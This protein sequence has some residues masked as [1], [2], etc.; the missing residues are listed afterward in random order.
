MSY[1]WDLKMVLFTHHIF[2]FFW[3]FYTKMN[4][5]DSYC[6]YVELLLAVVFNSVQIILFWSSKK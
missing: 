3:E 5:F 6:L 1:S 4:F 2:H